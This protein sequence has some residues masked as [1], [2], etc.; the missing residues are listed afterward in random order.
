MFL[1]NLPNVLAQ[2]A[3]KMGLKRKKQVFAFV[4]YLG[5]KINKPN[6]HYA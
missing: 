6:N 5:N 4:G 1:H 2:I 3:N